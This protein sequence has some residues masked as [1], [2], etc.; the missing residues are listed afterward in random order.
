MFFLKKTL[1]RYPQ[2]CKQVA[3]LR[4]ATQLC[5]QVA[6][7]STKTSLWALGSTWDIPW[8]AKLPLQDGCDSRILMTAASCQA[9]CKDLDFIKK[10]TKFN[11]NLNWNWKNTKKKK[12]STEMVMLPG[13]RCG[14]CFK[15]RPGLVGW[16]GTQATRVCGWVGSK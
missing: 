11:N 16:P 13:D 2:L 8:A 3:S 4:Q 1:L 10:S 7:E 12:K 15:T 14:Q 9:D 5:K 6:S